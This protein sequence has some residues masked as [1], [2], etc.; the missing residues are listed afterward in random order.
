MLSWTD[1]HASSVKFVKFRLRKMPT[2][3]M[4]A[5]ECRQ[6]EMLTGGNAN[7]AIYRLG[8]MPTK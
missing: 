8:K 2:E 4:L 7:W 3:K 6:G 5:G 1:E